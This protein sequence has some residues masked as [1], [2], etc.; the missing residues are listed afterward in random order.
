VFDWLADNRKE[1]KGW[2]LFY[3]YR[4]TNTQKENDV[5]CYACCPPGTPGG[6]TLVCRENQND[7]NKYCVE[8][9]PMEM[10]DT[11][12]SVLPGKWIVSKAKMHMDDKPMTV[13]TEG[14]MRVPF[15]SSL[16]TIPFGKLYKT[17]IEARS[18]KCVAKVY[19]EGFQGSATGGPR[20]FFLDA[21]LQTI[22]CADHFEKKYNA[23]PAVKS[24]KL[25][26]V[27]FIPVCVVCGT[28]I[29]RSVSSLNETPKV[30]EESDHMSIDGEITKDQD[31]EEQIFDDYK[32]TSFSFQCFAAVEQLL[33]GLYK[34]HNVSLLAVRCG[35]LW[36]SVC[37][38]HCNNVL[39]STTFSCRC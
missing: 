7:S 14:A 28:D 23:E 35:S 37:S 22:V 6:I 24:K 20:A 18:Q 31:L 32:H 2:L 5:W 9:K 16:R 4:T 17:L 13:K 21:Y 30:F 29:A 34:K 33:P 8:P 3:L 26:F 12:L 11:D 38:H 27:E 19:R 39:Y 25:K 15:L 1:L 10:A 36:V